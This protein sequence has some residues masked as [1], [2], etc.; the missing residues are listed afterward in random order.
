MANLLDYIAWRGDI[1]MARDEFNEVDGAVFA[2]L[3]Y[4]PFDGF[5]SE[6]TDYIQKLGDVA[7]ALCGACDIEAKNDS[8]NDEELI[9]SIKNSRRFYE[10]GICAYVNKSD[11]QEQTQFAAVTLK[12]SDKLYYIAFRGTDS[13]LIGW[14][15]DFNMSFT[16]PVPAQSSAIRYYE[17]IAER[18]KNARFI[19]GG[20]SKGGN[21]AVCAA[22]F[23]RPALQERVVSVYNYDGPG[24]DGNVINMDGYRRICNRTHTFLPQSSIVGMLL[25]HEEKYTVIHSIQNGIWQHNIYS[26]ELVRNRFVYLDSVT[27]SSRMIDRTLKEW[28]AGM[29]TEHRERLVDVV[30]NIMKDTNIQTIREMNEHRFV[31]AKAILKSTKNLD[32]PTR[33]VVT[34]SLGILF[35]SAGKSISEV[36]RKK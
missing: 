31:S 15:E 25:E 1:D 21:L 7:R 36:L 5:V 17:N 32:P 13:T 24:F 35:R 11:T 2:R 27:N 28:I 10:I 8:G 12:I 6:R 19:L 33:K 18:F 9:R 3:S 20:H 30:Y 29:S 23:C 34:Q 4:V 14:K 16:F 26:W 22:A